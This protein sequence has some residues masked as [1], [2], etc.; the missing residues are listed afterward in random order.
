MIRSTEY[1]LCCYLK[2]VDP[3]VQPTPHRVEYTIMAE[4]TDPYCIWEFNRRLGSVADT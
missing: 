4:E 2:A 3:D 1:L